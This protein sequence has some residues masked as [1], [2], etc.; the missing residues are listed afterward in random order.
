M[1]SRDRLVRFAV[2]TGIV[3]L[4]AAARIAPHPHNV[5][6]I[7]ALA[8]FGGA[9]FAN[10]WLGLGVSLVALLLGDLVIGFH[11]LVPFVYGGFAAIGVLGFGLR[12]ERS[13]G[14]VAGATVAGSLLFFLVTNFGMWWLFDTY[15]PTAAGLWA[16]YV[17]GLPYL[18][19][20]LAGNAAYVGLLF[21]GVALLKRVVPALRVDPAPASA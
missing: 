3:L 1:G 4:A 20:S 10:R 16:C 15:P 12:S 9:H 5:T 17:A 11:A 8:L 13:V 6:P 19:N 18:A 14:R 7:A 21:G 2:L